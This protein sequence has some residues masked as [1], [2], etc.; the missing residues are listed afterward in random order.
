MDTNDDKSDCIEIQSSV[1]SLA[2]D[3][4]E[5]L[6]K[7]RMS[8]KYLNSLDPIS[9]PIFESYNVQTDQ[10]VDDEKLTSILNRF[11]VKNKILEE[12]IFDDNVE[13]KNW[14]YEKK[15][16]DSNKYMLFLNLTTAGYRVNLKDD[17]IWI[18]SI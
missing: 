11:D 10:K 9:D 18:Q 3:I 14:I 2:S 8:S 7:K 5:T 13:V 4:F 17:Q 6:Q 12:T 1:D 15:L 16:S